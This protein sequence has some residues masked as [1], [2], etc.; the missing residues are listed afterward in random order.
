MPS[1]GPPCCG[2]SE[3]RL[4]P[5]ALR[6][7]TAIR[8]GCVRHGL[9]RK[10]PFSRRGSIPA[11]KHDRRPSVVQLNIEGLT[12]SKISVN[13]QL[14]YK[15]KALV[16]VLQETHCTTAD[17]P[18]ITNF[19]PAGSVLSRKHGLATFVHEHLEFKLVD[20]TLEQSQS[21]WLHVSINQS[22]NCIFREM[23][24]NA[25][26]NKQT[27]RVDEMTARSTS[28]STLI[29]NKEK[30]NQKIMLIAKK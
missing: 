14:A 9:G 3:I 7:T 2:I 27:A 12:A 24:K 30:G 28:Q 23:W 1:S 13:E 19:L 17:K 18:M 29:K 22:I 16:I 21:E 15:N 4:I 6:P 11:A 5:V 20:R 8:A 10:T 26:F 25:W